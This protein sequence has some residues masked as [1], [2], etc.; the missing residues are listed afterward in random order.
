MNKVVI[1]NDETY[2]ELQKL[3]IRIFQLILE[4]VV[5][6][7]SDLVSI[8]TQAEDD[9]IKHKFSFTKHNNNR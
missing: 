2:S 6:I 5:K 8:K 4:D 1:V 3:N 7:S 9:R